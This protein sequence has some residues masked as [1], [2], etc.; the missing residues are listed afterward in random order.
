MKLVVIYGPPAV[1]KLSVARELSGM[2]GYEL[3]HNHASLD[4]VDRRFGF[5]SREFN[6]AVVRYR[7]EKL[8]EAAKNGTNL[9]FT[10]AFIKGEHEFVAGR[11]REMIGAYGGEVCFVYLYADEET[12]LKR[13]KGESRKEFGKITEVDALKLFLRTH[14][15]TKEAPIKGSL[16]L[17]SSGM[18]ADSV[19]NLAVKIAERFEIKVLS[20]EK[21]AQG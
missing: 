19:H 11:L 7:A 20:K 2:T 12:L 9:I 16:V 6:E 17:D 4:A 13:V 21:T 5:G 10:S 8:T 18:N 1:G 3:F 14:E 15:V